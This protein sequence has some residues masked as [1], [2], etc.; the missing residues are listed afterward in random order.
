MKR[1]RIATSIVL[2]TTLA[3]SLRSVTAGAQDQSGSMAENGG[4]HLQDGD[5]RG[6]ELGRNVGRLALA[7]ARSPWDPPA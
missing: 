5:Q 7:H 1:T 2:V 3:L 6:R 4:I